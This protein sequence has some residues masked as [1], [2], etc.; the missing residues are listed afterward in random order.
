[1]NIF[2]ID[3]SPSEIAKALV[4]KHIVKMPVESAQMLST[5]KRLL[6]G[7]PASVPHWRNGK[8]KEKILYLL[9]GESYK[10]FK[11]PTKDGFDEWS[12]SVGYWNQKCYAVAHAHHPSTV[13]TMA[14]RTNYQWHYELFVEMMKEYSR[15][16]SRKHQ[17]E[18]L[19]HFLSRSPDN[20]PDGEFTPPTP[21]MPDKYKVESVL[22]SYRSFYAGEKWRFAK[23]KHG[24]MPAWFPHYMSTS[25]DAESCAEKASFILEVQQKKTLPMDERV[26][27]FGRKICYVQAE[28]L[29][30][31]AA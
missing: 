21:A 26:F 15:R 5:A 12:D 7:K 24:I 22:E 17:C 10:I 9:P 11:Q 20:I 23:W 27:N 3:E 28:A 18:Q 16:Y 14:N 29:N 31:L 6:D 2:Y 4:D 8:P 25:W 13:W 19:L 30:S 1:M